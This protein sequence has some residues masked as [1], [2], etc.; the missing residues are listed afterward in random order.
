MNSSKDGVQNLRSQRVAGGKYPYLTKSVSRFGK[1]MLYVRIG[2]G[3]RIRIAGRVGTAEF[4]L[5]YR[6]AVRE[7]LGGKAAPD[8]VLK[9]ETPVA[10]LGLKDRPLFVYVA[11]PTSARPCKIGVSTDPKKRIKHLRSGNHERIGIVFSR[12]TTRDIA[13]HVEGLIKTRLHDKFGLFGEWLDMDASD[14]SKLAD[15]AV[16][17]CESIDRRRQAL[18]TLPNDE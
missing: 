11:A 4:L 8:A 17:Y 12:E 13:F 18:A 6:T 2:K 15:E 9:V 5:N 7:L 10:T 3:R 16:R 14:L 1:V